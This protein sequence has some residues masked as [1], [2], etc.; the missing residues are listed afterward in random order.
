MRITS[1]SGDEFQLVIVRYQFPDVHE[2]RWESNWLIVNGT[3][4]AA[5]EKWV[6]TEPCVTTFELADLA[7]WLDELVANGTEPSAFEF[8]EPNL[9]FAYVPWPHR[10]VQL[11][12]AHESAPA[13]LSDVERRNGVTVEFPLSVQQT[14]TFAAEI[15]QALDEYPIRGG[16]A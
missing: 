10:A 14:A 15:R 6:F 4:A 9:K 5:G 13:S 12:L 7:D 8:T 11:T 3:I 2:D 1:A 16:A